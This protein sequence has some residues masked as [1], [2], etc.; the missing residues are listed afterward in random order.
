MLKTGDASGR[1]YYEGS[2]TPEGVLNGNPDMLER[3]Q[4]HLNLGMKKW[5]QFWQ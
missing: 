2:G 3:W 1:I 5:W 4:K